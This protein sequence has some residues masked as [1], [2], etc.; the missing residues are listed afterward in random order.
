MSTLAELIAQKIALEE[1]IVEIRK[2]ERTDAIAQAK[3]IIME[4][5]LTVED[6][7]SIISKTRGASTG[8]VTNKVQPKYRHPITGSTWTGR[9]MT[10]KWL[11]GK[12]RN[13]FLIA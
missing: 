3:T 13:E 5:E 12:D 10:P 7:F 1:K 4:N 11:E 2:T 9:G 8:K 6:L